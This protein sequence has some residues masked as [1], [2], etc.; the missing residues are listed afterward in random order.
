MAFLLRS[1]ERTGLAWVAA[2]QANC[3]AR[4]EGP[5]TRRAGDAGGPA[6]LGLG[7]FISLMLM[8]AV[9]ARAD[10]Q[11]TM[12]VSGARRPFAAQGRRGGNGIK[13]LNVNVDF[14]QV[15][16]SVVARADGSGGVRAVTV[17]KPVDRTSKDF[18]DALSSNENLTVV[19]TIEQTSADDGLPIWRLLRLSGAKVSAIHDAMDATY[20]SPQGMGV[21]TVTFTCQKVEVE[22]DGL[23]VFSSGG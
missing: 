11:I 19:I 2:P 22:D 16:T 6:R 7:L 8:R 5:G 17:T 3:M 9:A 1:S 15:D 12:S 10:V 14:G 23:Q 18:L 13:V 20:S 4:R 21:E